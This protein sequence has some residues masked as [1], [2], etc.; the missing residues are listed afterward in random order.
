MPKRGRGCL[1]SFFIMIYLFVFIVSLVALFLSQKHRLGIWGYLLSITPSVLLA[2]FRDPTI[3]TDTSLYV[4]SVFNHVLHEKDLLSALKHITFVESGYVGFNYLVSR[5]SSNFWGYLFYA[6]F[7]MYSTIMYALYRQRDNLHIWIGA[8]IFFFVFYRE[9]LNTA[10]QFMALSLDVLSFSYLISKKYK[11]SLAIT[12]L[13]CSFH[14]SNIIFFFVIFLYYL[15][16][17]YYRFFK[18]NLMKLL[19]ILG[20]VASMLMMTYIL[21]FLGG[22]DEVIQDKYMA[23][24]GNSER[25]GTNIPL[26][27][28]SLTIMNLLVFYYT[29]FVLDK[30]TKE[31]HIF[32]FFEYILISS[33]LMCFLGQI[34]SNAV[35]I[36]SYFT[37]MSIIL[38]PILYCKYK[39]P[40]YIRIIHLLFFVFYWYMT[41]INANLGDT[42][43][44]ILSNKV[45]F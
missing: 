31:T 34:S 13:G 25:F 19:L 27:L 7:F 26:S 11:F 8:F 4:Q 35:R 6:H 42:Y 36:G 33:F 18:S 2:A 24:Y 9:S 16:D 15:V 20:I 43:P 28:F 14:H 38:F 17:N 41:V 32:V 21:S 40:A 23:R 3:G 37:Y 39:M 44:Y 29:K 45:P 12:L 1:R 5:I 30:S 22:F 10:R